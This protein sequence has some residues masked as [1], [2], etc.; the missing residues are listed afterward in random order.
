MAE[1]P[2]PKILIADDDPQSRQ[3]IGSVLEI[4]GYQLLQARTGEEAIQQY[5]SQQPDLAILDINMPRINGLEVCRHIRAQPAGQDIPIL[6]ITALDDM[7]FI[8]QA[9]SAG[10]S[11]YI[12]KPL[13]L[14]VLQRRVHHLLQLQ[15]SEQDRRRAQSQ[16]EE[17]ERQYRRIIEE[18]NDI[19]Y[20]TD[21]EGYF[22]YVNPSGA[23]LTGFSLESLIG[24]HFTEIVRD[25][26]RDKLVDYYRQQVRDRKRETSLRFPILNST[27]QVMWVEQTTTLLMERTQLKGFQSILRDVTENYRT[28]EI[29]TKR[30]RELEMLNE[31]SAAIVSA[32]DLNE[33]LSKVA[34]SCCHI[35]K[36]TSVY[37]CDIDLEKRTTIVQAEYMSDSAVEAEQES[38][39]GIVYSIDQDF[40]GLWLDIKTPDQII[41]SH[42]DDNRLPQGTRDHMAQ[43]GAKTTIQKFLVVDG[44]IIGYLELWESRQKLTFSDDEMQLLHSIGNQ[45]ALMINKA[46][47]HH[48]L[49]QSVQELEA[50]NRELDAYSH[51]IAHDLKTPLNVVIGYTELVFTRGRDH[52]LPDDFSNYLG[53]IKASALKMT[54]MINQLLYLA[55]LRNASEAMVSVDM[56]VVVSDVMTRFDNQLEE[57]NIEMDV[58]AGMPSAL[59]HVVWLEE[60]FANLIGNAIHYMGND[61]PRQIRISGEQ[62]DDDVCYRV[63]DTGVG[64]SPKNQARLFEM[65]TRFNDNATDGTGLGL[66]I[67]RRI[68]TKMNGTL[69]VE[70]EEGQGSTFWFTLPLASSD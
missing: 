50:R 28:Q 51:T 29:L 22:T 33:L 49:E 7:D 27:N 11:D 15:K 47:L 10:A 54:Q 4:D 21:A 60:V 67:V 18:A 59:G 14:N 42:S 52:N 1:Q 30:N 45:V 63:A 40:P 43:Y 23:S 36:V 53:R 69:G 64:I 35:F 38:D 32:T 24:K 2:P 9:F 46:Q 6:M 56:N 31:L 17:R 13:R 41:I 12:N 3:M 34:E 57:K 19:I 37:V 68:V 8:D 26:W 66:S 58:Q 20:V 48:Q 5:D 39:L 16:L 61:D 65:F 70:S 62:Q 25:D 44:E 55:N